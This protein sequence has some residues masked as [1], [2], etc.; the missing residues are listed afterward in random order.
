MEGTFF[1]LIVDGVFPAKSHFDGSFLRLRHPRRILRMSREIGKLNGVFTALVLG[2]I[3]KFPST[4]EN[5]CV[6]ICC[7]ELCRV[8]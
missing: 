2:V 6:K 8:N 1:S 5:F 4:L 7:A 3:L